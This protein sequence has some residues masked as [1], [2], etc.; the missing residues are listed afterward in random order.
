MN[1]MMSGSIKRIRKTNGTNPLAAPFE[2]PLPLA[3]P[4]AMGFLPLTG[5]L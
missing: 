3:F 2:T 5:A 4:F 1:R